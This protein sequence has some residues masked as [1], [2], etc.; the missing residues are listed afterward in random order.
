M[1]YIGKAI[2]RLSRLDRLMALPEL[3]DIIKHNELRIALEPLLQVKS[4]IVEITDMLLEVYHG[5]KKEAHD[6]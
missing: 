2:Y 1:Q 4:G 3:P 6:E 5:T